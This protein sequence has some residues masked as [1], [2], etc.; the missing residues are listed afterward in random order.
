MIPA[1]QSKLN[2][3]RA[4]SRQTAKSHEQF[5][6]CS[7]FLQTPPRPLFL[8]L[9]KDQFVEVHYHSNSLTVKM[10]SEL[11][12]KSGENFSARNVLT[13]KMEIGI[14]K[15]QLMSMM[16]PK[17]TRQMYVETCKELQ[18]TTSLNP[19]NRNRRRKTEVYKI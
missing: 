10:T 17:V 8:W 18:Y 1:K 16:I 3:S 7:T 5:L 4:K 11:S 14:E 6:I 2:L 12:P 19:E 15:L 9:L 13:P